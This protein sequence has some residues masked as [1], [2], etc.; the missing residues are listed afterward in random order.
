M[1]TLAVLAR[2]GK[3]KLND[4]MPS[5]KVGEVPS[6]SLGIFVGDMVYELP[7]R[8]NIFTLKAAKSTNHIQ[9]N[10]QVSYNTG[11]ADCI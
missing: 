9:T 11:V 8:L 6:I 1:E 3:R 2:P 10:T 7:R 5:H 4:L